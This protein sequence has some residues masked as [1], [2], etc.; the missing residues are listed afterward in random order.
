MYH[1]TSDLLQILNDNSNNT[2][3]LFNNLN[4][5]INNFFNNLKPDDLNLGINTDIDNKD[6]KV[7]ILN[8]NDLI[9]H[10]INE[11]IKLNH[12]INIDS[13]FKFLIIK[14]LLKNIINNFD[15][16][17]IVINNKS[18]YNNNNIEISNKLVRKILNYFKNNS[19]DYY[20]IYLKYQNF[21]TNNF[22][23]LNNIYNYISNLYQLKNLKIIDSNSYNSDY[24][25][26]YNY[27]TEYLLLKG[28]IKKNL[29]DLKL[30]L[31]KL[32]FSKFKI[33]IFHS[34]HLNSYKIT[35]KNSVIKIKKNKS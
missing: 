5:N 24:S 6:T 26:Y 14:K 8:I 17:I 4:N 3:V 19:K 33:N 9:K 18:I 25:E 10:N 15:L 30:S 22:D 27:Y 13:D 34:D 35:N 31:L 20:C 32:Y 11:F 1:L 2:N 28:N 23:N 21:N 16:F 29:N 12:L 7:F